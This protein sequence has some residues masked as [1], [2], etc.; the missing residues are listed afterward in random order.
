MEKSLQLKQIPSS[1]LGEAIT[2]FGKESFSNSNRSH[3]AYLGKKYSEFVEKKFLK[4]KQVP[5]SILW[6]EITWFGEVKFLQIE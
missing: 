4:L 2:W 1:T 6:K 3:I 5:S